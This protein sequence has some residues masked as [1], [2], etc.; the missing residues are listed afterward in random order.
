LTEIQALNAKV[1]G[2]QRSLEKKSA[3]ELGESPEIDLFED[4]KAKFPNDRISRV[5]KGVAGADIE[6]G[7]MHN[8]KECAKVVID[9]KNRKA[10]QW[11]SVA[12]L[13]A[14]QTAAKADHAILSTWRLPAGAKEVMEHNGVL[15]TK[16]AHVVFLVGVLRQPPALAP[17]NVDKTMLAPVTAIVGY[18]LDFPDLLPK[19]FPQFDARAWFAGN[20]ALIA[21]TAYRNGSLQGAYLILALRAVGLD[22][23]PMSGFDPAKVDAEFFVGTQVRT[24]FLINIGYGDTTKLFP[25]SPRLAFEEMAHFA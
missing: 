17:Q 19:L 5:A 3:D 20:A 9:S 14:D 10:W 24:N 6:H 12:K 11:D 8:D 25:R 18:D 13:S 15:I 1:Q 22:V 7:F 2:L 4:L 16:P 23:G 21:D